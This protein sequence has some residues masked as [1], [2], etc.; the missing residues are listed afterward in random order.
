MRDGGRDDV[1]REDGGAAICVDPAKGAIAC[2]LAV[3]RD[4]AISIH[5]PAQGATPA[6][7]AAPP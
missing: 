4:H 2:D 6:G 7:N 3:P 1:G 5:A